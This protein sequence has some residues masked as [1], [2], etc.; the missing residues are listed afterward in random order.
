MSILDSLSIPVII[1][2]MAGGPSTPELVSAAAGNGTFGFLAGGVIG[3]EE[4]RKNMSQVSGIFGVNLF[5]PQVQRPHPADIDAL[6]GQLT[7]DF[8]EYGLS[9][10]QIPDVD[11]SNGWTEK[12]Q[13]VLDAGPAVVS[14]TFGM[15]T[16]DEFAQLATAGIEAWVSVSN[17]E[18]AAIA[19]AAGADV[20]VVQGPE[21][22]GHRSTWTITEDPDTRS[23]EELLAAIDVG[24]PFVATGGISTASAVAR[25][26][27]CGAS[28]VACGTAFLLAEEAG[29][30]AVNRDII[31]AGG[32]TVSTRAFSGRYARGAAT[33]FT[34]LN[35]SL[36]PLYPYLNALSAPLRK[37]SAARG[38]WDFAYCLAGVGMAQARE[39]KTKQI[40]M[41]LNPSA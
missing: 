3:V 9:D 19:E 24:I 1:A 37:A 34:R 36:P 29:T 41:E 4:L 31:K 16:A 7:Q 23:V 33:T 26:L 27:A 30:S 39:A 22:G 2:P 6:A 17:P 28:A 5:R 21:A 35:E 13:A 14:S 8:R 38:N 40:L 12:F 18:D 11:L 15:F 10:P 20:L 25:L 32:E